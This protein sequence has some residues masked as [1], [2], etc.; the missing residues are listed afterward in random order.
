MKV[1]N[2]NVFI[3]TWLGRRINSTSL[4]ESSESKVLIHHHDISYTK[5]MCVIN[6]SKGGRRLEVNAMYFKFGRSLV[7]IL[8]ITLLFVISMILT[9]FYGVIIFRDGGY[10]EWSRFTK[11]TVSCGGKTIFC[12]VF[13]FVPSLFV[14]FF[15]R[16]FP[17]LGFF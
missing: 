3:R 10:T 8:N 15:T 1:T 4:R 14:L 7:V 12:S 16:L 11:C 13:R 5:N 17:R 6:I 9:E 2:R